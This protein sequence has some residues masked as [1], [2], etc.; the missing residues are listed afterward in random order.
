MATLRPSPRIRL[1]E[2]YIFSRLD[3]RPNA[4]PVVHPMSRPILTN[5]LMRSRMNVQF[6]RAV[7][8]RAIVDY[9]GLASDQSL[10]SEDGYKRLTADVLLTW[11]LHPGTA[12]SVGYS[13]QYENERLI[14]VVPPVLQRTGA[15]TMPL[16]RQVFVKFSYL[17]RL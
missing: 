5:Q 4:P 1:D 12:F 16:A 14:S 9:N 6:T 13:D 2:I 11:M 15:P 8:L 3:T 17:W 10:V 7:S